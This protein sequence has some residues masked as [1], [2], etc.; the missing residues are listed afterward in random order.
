MVSRVAVHLRQ[1]R[2]GASSVPTHVE[3]SRGVLVTDPVT[4]LHPQEPAPARDIDIMA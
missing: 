2:P 1:N 3:T 4:G